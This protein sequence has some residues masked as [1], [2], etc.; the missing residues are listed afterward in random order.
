MA[1]EHVV[2]QFC[3]RAIDVIALQPYGDLP[4]PIQGD[5][6]QTRAFIH[7]D[8]MIDGLMLLI[9]HGAHMNIYNVGNSEEISI[10]EVARRIV[11]CFGRNAALIPLDLP[12][13]STVRRCPDISKLRALGFAP[14][15]PFAQGIVPVVTWYR[16]YAHLQ[17][18]RR[19]T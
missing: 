5:G 8:D 11:A 16:D 12:P 17:P 10:A 19:L 1:W 2:P 7:I 13:G 18:T 6:S 9:E 14:K 4:F 15:I 3:L